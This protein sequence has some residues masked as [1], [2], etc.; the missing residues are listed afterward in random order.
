MLC[1][2]DKRD[3]RVVSNTLYT[4]FSGRGEENKIYGKEREKGGE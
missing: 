4:L 2:R 3:V 1:F